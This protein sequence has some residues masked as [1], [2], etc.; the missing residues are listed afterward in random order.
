M[1]ILIIGKSFPY[2]GGIAAFNERLAMQLMQEGHAVEIYTY[3][4]IYSF[5]TSKVSDR[6][7]DNDKTIDVIV[8]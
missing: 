3:S 2:K 8:I 5:L 7:Y 4:Y 6:F 1:K